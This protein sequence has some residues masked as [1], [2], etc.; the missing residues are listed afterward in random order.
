VEIRKAVIS[1]APAW[2]KLI[3]SVKSEDLPV[4]YKNSVIIT[5]ESTTK[6]LKRILENEGSFV[7]LCFDGEEIIG[8][9]DL[10]RKSRIEE[11]HVALIGMCVLNHYRRKGIGTRLLE[12]L[13]EVCREEK[14][15][16]K[17]EFDVFSNNEIAM[18]LYKKL[19]YEIEGIR[20]KSIVKNGKEIDIINMGKYIG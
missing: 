8:S 14:K 1:D 18:S 20:K 4:L 7:L 10:I 2:N 11:Q 16:R 13:E 3:T 5:V 6:Y 15:I 9:I 19:N 17:I 12:K